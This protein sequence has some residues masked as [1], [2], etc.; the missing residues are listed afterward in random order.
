MSTRLTKIEIIRHR[1]DRPNIHNQLA[2]SINHLIALAPPNYVPIVPQG[3]NK[4]IDRVAAR[5]IQEAAMLPSVRDNNTSI[6]QI[7]E[8]NIF[9]IETIYGYLRIIVLCESI[10]GFSIGIS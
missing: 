1:I 8:N 9:S 2:A 5:D 10:Y 6:G 3:E 7:F 4:Y